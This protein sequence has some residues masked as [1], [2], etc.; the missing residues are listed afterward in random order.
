VLEVFELVGLHLIEVCLKFSLLFVPLINH[1]PR[2]LGWISEIP[3]LRVFILSSPSP[4]DWESLLP[5]EEYETDFSSLFELCKN[6]QRIDI[7][8][9]ERIY[10]RW[11]RDG[12]PP[13][14]ISNFYE[15]LLPDWDIS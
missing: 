13:S 14:Y 15:V 10:Q 5:L 6:L 4:C 12:S 1:T 8:I 3:M 2:K 9:E 11:L 7:N